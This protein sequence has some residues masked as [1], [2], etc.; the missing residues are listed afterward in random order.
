MPNWIDPQFAMIVLAL[1]AILL[2]VGLRGVRVDR[3]PRCRA[4][5]CRYPLRELLDAKRNA[6]EP[7]WPVTCPECGR[8]METPSRAKWGARRAVRAMVVI[9]AL[10]AA[11]SIG[12]LGLDAYARAQSVRAIGSMPVWALLHLAD[13]DAEHNDWRHQRELLARARAG[14]ITRAEAER[15]AER[16]L[17]WQQDATRTVR[18]AG[19]LFWELADPGLLPQRQIDQF[20][21]HALRCT[22][23]LP[24]AV[25]R[26]GPF[27]FAVRIEY[28]GGGRLPSS[29]LPSS[30]GDDEILA[31]ALF[32]VERLAINGREISLEGRNPVLQYIYTQIDRPTTIHRSFFATDPV[33]ASIVAPSESA[34]RATI[35]LTIRWLAEPI[36]ARTTLEM[37]P[38]NPPVDV[39]L[40]YELTRRNLATTRLITLRGEARAAPTGSLVRRTDSSKEM[41]AYI[42]NLFAPATLE[43]PDLSPYD[44]GAIV[45]FGPLYDRPTP[46]PTPTLFLA[47]AV[48]RQGDESIPTLWTQGL[49]G[50]HPFA[51][52]V[53]RRD[54][55]DRLFTLVHANPEGWELVLTPRPDLGAY[56]ANDAPAVAGE[57]IVIP[58][59]VKI[60]GSRSRQMRPPAPE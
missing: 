51:T 29:Y 35:E 19:D 44:G 25:E 30:Y 8:V 4:R 48:I 49:A 11:P 28:R 41:R 50:Q 59:T 24:S 58:L 26:D 2:A 47:D 40:T 32:R 53:P 12:V 3:D 56:V 1:G 36:G 16:I 33:W 45:V 9:G 23:L 13:R 31:R 57:P 55:H 5:R 42:E 22:L 39:S 34:D 20:W 37:T 43:V 17:A 52:R 60:G 54:D 38:G 15:I 10:L 6:S 46:P 21:E 14:A 27:P 18:V 7:E